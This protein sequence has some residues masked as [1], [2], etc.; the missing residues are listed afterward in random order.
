MSTYHV[1][2]HGLATWPSWDSTKSRARGRTVGH[3]R[4]LDGSGKDV[5]APR[6]P[7]TPP[8]RAIAHPCMGTRNPEG[9]RAPPLQEHCVR[10]RTTA[11]LGSSTPDPPVRQR[12]V[13][14]NH[15]CSRRGKY[16][17]RVNDSSAAAETVPA[18]ALVHTLTCPDCLE[19]GT[20]CERETSSRRLDFDAIGRYFRD[21]AH[22]FANLGRYGI[23]RG[24]GHTMTRDGLFREPR[25][26]CRV[27]TSSTAR[28]GSRHSAARC[29]ARRLKR[30][31]SPRHPQIGADRLRAA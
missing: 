5:Q 23:E 7:D 20:G 19:S 4:V 24:A 17:K 15:R 8:R 10:A 9:L 13:Y 27:G 31:Q 22:I 29:A 1:A 18:R 21:E 12:S 2:G 14:R 28:K 3:A 11:V 6:Q 16:Q 26:N 25:Q 30:H